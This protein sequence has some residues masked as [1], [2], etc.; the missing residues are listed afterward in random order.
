VGETSA[1]AV[2]YEGDIAR[3]LARRAA[4]VAPLVVLGCGLGW[5][6][7]GAV[8][9]AIGLVLVALNFLAAARV[10]AWAAPQGGSMVM[11]AVLGGYLLRLIVLLGIVL[12]LQQVGW[13]NIPVLVVTLAVTHLALL[14]WEMRYVSF[15]LAAPGLQRAPKHKAG[16]P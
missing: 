9:A 13:L 8:S 1:V 2:A 3:D 7:S 16:H 11:A 12:A 4:L 6:A 10:L 5:G 14:T 15:S